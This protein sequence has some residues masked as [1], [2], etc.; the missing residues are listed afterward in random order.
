[1]WTREDFKTVYQR[2]LD[3]GMKVR[4]FC[5]GEE[6]RESRFFYWQKRIRDEVANQNGTFLPVSMNN[7]SGKV[8]LVNEPSQSMATNTRRPAAC[9]ISYPNGVTVRFSG[10]VTAEVLKRLIMLER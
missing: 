6:I 8:I 2:Y 9:E 1:M 5:A 3:S 4:E 7:H 10:E